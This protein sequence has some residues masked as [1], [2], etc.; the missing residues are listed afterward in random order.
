MRIGIDGRP[1]Q[2]RLTGIGRYV[3]ELCKELDA[4]LP[5]AQFY[6]YTNR[7]ISFTLPSSRWIVRKDPFKLSSRIPSVLW[8]QFFMRNLV[9]KDKINVLWAGG[10][11][12]P[13]FLPRKIK[14]IITVHDLN[15]KLVPET[16]KTTHCWS[17]KLFFGNAIRRAD[18]ITTISKGTSKRLFEFYGKSADE[19]IYPSVDSQFYLPPEEEMRNNLIHN[20]IPQR[21]LLAVGTMEPR[22]NIHLL[23]DVF[24]E[25]KKN[26]QIPEHYLVIVG[27]N[28]WKLSDL[29]KKTDE[30]S[31]V[32]IIYLGY[33]DNSLLRSVYAGA[34]LFVFPSIYEGFGMP[35]S[36]AL[37]CGAKVLASDIPE[38]RE[39][40]GEH[41]NITYVKPSFEGI[42]NGILKMI[43]IPKNSNIKFKAHSWHNEA[44]KLSKLMKI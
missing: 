23:H 42:Y 21:Y 37:C 22:K 2:G 10:V 34:D 6:I 28:G 40:G 17:F 3:A 16:I 14:T 13:L 44:E 39:A 43:S 35:V 32:N 18:Y 19:V 8:I 31:Y 24:I 20:G 41:P 9:C 38:T 29:R 33:I 7:S 25:L 5:E 26:N 11:F 30:N 27:G 36:E 4:L 1:L 15:H 12:V